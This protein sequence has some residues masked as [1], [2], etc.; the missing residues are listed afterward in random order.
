[1]DLP[2]SKQRR[3]AIRPAIFSAVA[4]TTV[5]AVA[6]CGGGSSAGTSSSSGTSQSSTVQKCLE[7]H[8]VTKPQGAGGGGAGGGSGATPQAR[9]TGSGSSSLKQAMEAC[10]GSGGS[11]S[12]SAG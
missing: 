6:G 3:R 4:L 1:L 2:G 5:I 10:R 9:P 11:K 7:E 8:G 12:G